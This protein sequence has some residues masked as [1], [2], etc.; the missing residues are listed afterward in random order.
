MTFTDRFLRLPI[1]V[2]D[3]HVKNLTGKENLYD[4]WIKINPHQIESY[5]PTNPEG[6]DDKDTTMVYMKSGDSSMINM[7]VDEF[8]ELLNNFILNQ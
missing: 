3:K 5:R 2:Y 1:A 7:P 4:S 6:E 8:E